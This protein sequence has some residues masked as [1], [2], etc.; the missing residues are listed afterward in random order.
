LTNNQIGDDETYYIAHALLTNNVVVL[1]FRLR[2]WCS[3]S[4]RIITK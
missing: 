2:R 3:I 4:D 1:I